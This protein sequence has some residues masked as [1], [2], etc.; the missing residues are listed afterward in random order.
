M[1]QG[2]HE[3][4]VCIWTGACFSTAAPKLHIAE[5]WASTKGKDSLIGVITYLQ[6][7]SES[8]VAFVKFVK[9]VVLFTPFTN[10]L[11]IVSS[12]PTQTHESII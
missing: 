8:V 2:M 10:M 4:V 6:N 9:H 1:A 7:L 12:L 5:L 3:E 11:L